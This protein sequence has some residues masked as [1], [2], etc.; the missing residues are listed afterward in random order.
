MV[1]KVYDRNLGDLT[2]GASKSRGTE[3]ASGKT[4]RSEVSESEV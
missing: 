4:A 2:S 3:D 1:A